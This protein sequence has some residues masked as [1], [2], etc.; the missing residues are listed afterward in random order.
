MLIT[1]SQ[2]IEKVLKALLFK[3]HENI[4]VSKMVGTAAVAPLDRSFL[5]IGQ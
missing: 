2:I 3:A 5:M 1:A 4:I